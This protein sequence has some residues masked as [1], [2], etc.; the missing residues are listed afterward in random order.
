MTKKIQ[1]HIIEVSR[2]TEFKVNVKIM[3]KNMIT[4]N[5]ESIMTGQ[6]LN[7]KEALRKTS[8]VIYLGLNLFYNEAV[9]QLKLKD[10]FIY[11]PYVRKS[12]IM[13]YRPE[14]LK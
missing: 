3:N 13:K 2:K 5:T 1:G 4:M 12:L 11:I 14:L 8:Q 9:Y 6:D 7:L 10:G